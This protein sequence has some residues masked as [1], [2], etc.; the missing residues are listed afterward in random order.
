MALQHAANR[1]AVVVELHCRLGVRA[2]HQPLVTNAP[3]IANA[4]LVSQTKKQFARLH[5][6]LI[7][8]IRRSHC[9]FSVSHLPYSQRERDS[10]HVPVDQ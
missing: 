6:K 5:T 1:L 4:A 8:A 9:N 10:S 3:Q 7:N 2:A